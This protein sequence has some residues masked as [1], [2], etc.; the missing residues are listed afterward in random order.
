[1]VAV[2]TLAH[3]IPQ[4]TWVGPLYVNGRKRNVVTNA[5]EKAHHPIVAEAVGVEWVARISQWYFDVGD[6]DQLMWRVA[7]IGA[8]SSA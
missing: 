4:L 1:M 5:N 6:P 8:P 3:A 7:T 2:Y